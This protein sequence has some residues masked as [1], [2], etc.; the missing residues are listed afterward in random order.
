MRFPDT[1]LAI[2]GGYLR[3]LEAEHVNHSY[4]EGLNDPIVNKYLEVRH[5]VQ[6]L[7]SVK[8]FVSANEEA[9]D[10]VLWGIWVDD[11]HRLIG[12]VRLHG[13]DLSKGDCH[14]GICIFDRCAWGKALASSSIKAVSRWAFYQFGLKKIYAGVDPKNVASG[15]AFL[16]AG[17]EFVSRETSHSLIFGDTEQKGIFIA[18]PKFQN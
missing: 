8:E 12:S 7:G 5:N 9:E 13:I 17:F 4:V 15:K 3:Q 14:L 10:G 11:Q 2:H 18:Y 1:C 6:T 16:K